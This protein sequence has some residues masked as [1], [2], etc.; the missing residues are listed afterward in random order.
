MT[1]WAFLRT[2]LLIDRSAVSVF[3][4]LCIKM[5]LSEAKA[6]VVSSSGINPLNWLELS[7]QHVITIVLKSFTK[8]S[9]GFF[10]VA[11]LN[12]HFPSHS[13]LESRCINFHPAIG[14]SSFSTIAVFTQGINTLHYIVGKNFF[15]F[16][17]GW[18]SI[19]FEFLF[20]PPAGISE[21]Q[22]DCPGLRSLFSH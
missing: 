2:K 7:F 22:F 11:G 6:Q 13:V 18:I 4:L 14:I 12:L 20:T 15:L 8:K 21:Q 9:H 19:L 17:Y 10:P 5:R 3:T 16:R 1:L